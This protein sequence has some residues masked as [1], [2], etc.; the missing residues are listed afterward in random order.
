MVQINVFNKNEDKSEETVNVSDQEVKDSETAVEGDKE[1]DI[2]LEKMS[3]K[4]LIKKIVDLQESEKKNYSLYL[5]GQADIENLKKRFQKEKG[6]LIKFSNDTLIKQLLT[7]IDNLEK[8]VEHGEN[9][10]NLKG[11]IE[12]VELTHKGL[13]NILEKSG[14][15]V[16]TPLGEPFDPNYHEAMFELED[17]SAEPGT[18]VKEL[19]KGYLLNER[20]L[21]PAMVAVSKRSKQY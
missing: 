3:K 8:A 5:R 20:L 14:L 15:E 13:K 9:E 7:V 18:V 10:N 21:R 11:L 6:D 4:E 17:D 16:I 1:K 12:G 19:Q 2:P